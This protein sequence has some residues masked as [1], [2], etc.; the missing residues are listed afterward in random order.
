MIELQT[1]EDWGYSVKLKAEK[2]GEKWIQRLKINPWSQLKPEHLDFM[3]K[4]KTEIIH[5]LIQRKNF[6]E[7]K[8]VSIPSQFKQ[9]F[10]KRTKQI[11]SDC[12][13]ATSAIK[14]GESWTRFSCWFCLFNNN[15][16][17]FLY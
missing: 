17:N 8:K 6:A 4:N 13:V 7:S 11:D 10:K 9:D 3:Q 5:Q 15:A 16:I 12:A 14:G 1:V 2:D